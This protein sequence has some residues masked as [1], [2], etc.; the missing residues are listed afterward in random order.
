M[1]LFGHWDPGFTDELLEK[2]GKVPDLV[3]WKR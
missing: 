2:R 1:D 3:K